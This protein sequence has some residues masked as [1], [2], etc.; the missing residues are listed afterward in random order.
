MKTSSAKAKGRK[1]QQWFASIMVKTLNL[2]EEDLESRPMGSQGEDI[3]MGRESRE[4]FPYSI[5]C[6]NQEAVNVWKAYEQASTNCKGYE[7]L[8]VIKRNRSKPLVLVD[9][10]HFVA[11]HKKALTPLELQVV[12]HGG[13][14]TKKIL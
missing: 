10:E 13:N 2:H 7:P 9:A 1:L 12:E 5:E 14:L 8:V 11:L 6:K 3:I 4:K